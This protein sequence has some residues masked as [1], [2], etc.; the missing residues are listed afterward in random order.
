MA[1]MRAII[2]LLAPLASAAILLSACAPGGTP[3]SSAN[4]RRIDSASSPKRDSVVKY[5]TADYQFLASLHTQG[6]RD[7][8]LSEFNAALLDPA[9]ENAYHNNEASLRRLSQSLPEEDPLWEFF[10]KTVRASWDECQVDHYSACAREQAP[11]FYGGIEWERQEDVFGDP[12]TTAWSCAD[13]WYTYSPGEVTVG[14]RDDFLKGI[15]E[16]MQS[17]LDGYTGDK[18]TDEKAMETLLLSELERLTASWS[19]GNF[20]VTNCQVSY[21]ISNF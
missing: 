16:G 1:I 3:E 15:S 4:T 21:H 10:D 7:R 20:E 18:R 12:V 5:T 11:T 2:K 9:D 17:Y 13:F 19:G 14:A 6:F 8:S